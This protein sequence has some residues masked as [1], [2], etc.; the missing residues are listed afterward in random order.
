MRLIGLA[1]I[2]VVSLILAPLV[3]EVLPPYK[4]LRTPGSSQTA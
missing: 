1:A 2:L 4:L 3:A